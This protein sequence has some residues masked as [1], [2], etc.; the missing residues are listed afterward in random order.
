MH[1]Q[2]SIGLRGKYDSHECSAR[3]LLRRNVDIERFSVDS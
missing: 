1:A 3:L 2:I